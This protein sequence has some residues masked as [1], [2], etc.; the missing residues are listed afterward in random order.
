[1]RHPVT[2]LLLG[3]VQCIEVQISDKTLDEYMSM[4]PPLEV[5][6]LVLQSYSAIFDEFLIQTERIVTGK[7]IQSIPNNCL[8][9]V[10]VVP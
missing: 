3:L 9:K 4:Q 10:Y 1:M 2:D 7:F 8:P 5:V 6:V